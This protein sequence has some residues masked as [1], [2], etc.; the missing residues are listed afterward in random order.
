VEELLGREQ[1]CGRLREIVGRARQGLS[2]VLVLRGEPG[3]GKTALLG[4]AQAAA[5][6]FDVVRFD[7][8]ETEAELGFAALYQLLRPH[9]GRL[10]SLPARRAAVPGGPGRPRTCDRR[11]MR[12]L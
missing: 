5:D 12:S 10:E 1:E 2:G 6:G 11:I 7:G 9:L 3:S 4:Y 8:V